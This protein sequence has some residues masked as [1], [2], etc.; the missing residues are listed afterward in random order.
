[1][2]SLFDIA[3]QR[4]LVTGAAGDFGR[5]MVAG[6]VERGCRVAALDSDASALEAAVEDWHKLAVTA[7][8]RPP[9][10]LPVV[11]DVSDEGQVEQAFH[12]TVAGAFGGLDLLVNNAGVMLRSEPENTEFQDWR[13]LLGINL[14]GAFLCARAAGRLML[15]QGRGSIVNIASI[16]AIKALDKRVA[17]GTSKAAIAHMTRV[18]ALEWGAKG[19]R[20]NA[21]APGFIRSRM[22]AD[23]RADPVRSEQMSSQVPLKRFGEPEELL[24]ALVFLASPSASYVNG[25]L[26]FVDG[27]LQVT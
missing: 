21:I 23:L 5:A 16:A 7:K 19:I 8:D 11:A 17:Y 9:E 13:R 22:N 15:P 14:D 25:H 26:L 1:M 18:L 27:G 24:G 6:L 2:D 12:E 4:A 10:V 3:G 20:V